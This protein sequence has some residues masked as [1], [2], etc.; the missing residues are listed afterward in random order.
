MIRRSTEAELITYSMLFEVHGTT[1]KQPAKCVSHI[2]RNGVQ[3]L[4]RSEMLKA[5]I[6]DAGCVNA[7]VVFSS[8]MLCGLKLRCT[9]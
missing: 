1:H 4:G 9:V 8:C 2:F 3:G 6:T 5:A 7:P